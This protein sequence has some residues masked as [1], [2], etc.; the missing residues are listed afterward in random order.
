MPWPTNSRT[1]ENPCASTCA[2]TAWPM[3]E[4][5]AAEPHL[6][7][8]PCSS[9]SCVTRSSSLASSRDRADRHRHR[10]VAVE[11]VQLHAHVERDDVALDAAARADGIPCTT[12]SFT[13]AQSVAG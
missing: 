9:A 3:S 11:P 8:S 2:W 12:C 13:D 5:R 1:T 4:T 6:R 10:R 7:R